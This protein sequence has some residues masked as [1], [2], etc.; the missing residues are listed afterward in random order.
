MSLY[1]VCLTTGESFRIA[2]TACMNTS[3]I[4]L[5]PI[6]P[7]ELDE[8]DWVL[9]FCDVSRASSWRRAEELLEGKFKDPD[10]DSMSIQRHFFHG[11]MAKS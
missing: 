2:D 9:D 3:E 4:A 5:A 7:V 8:P 10:P 11:I 6:Q 1:F